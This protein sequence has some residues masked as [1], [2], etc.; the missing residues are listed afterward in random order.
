MPMRPPSRRERA[1]QF[2]PRRFP[3]AK[4]TRIRTIAELQKIVKS[5]PSQLTLPELDFLR[6]ASRQTKSYLEHKAGARERQA[7]LAREGRDIG[8]IPAVADPNRKATAC[9]SLR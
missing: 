4:P 6:R 3:M 7:K 2:R 8:E 5:D 9:A 1:V